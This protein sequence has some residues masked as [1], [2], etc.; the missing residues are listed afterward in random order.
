MKFAQALQVLEAGGYVFRRGWNGKQIVLFLIRGTDL[1][2]VL[3]YGYGEYVGEPTFES[4][5]AIRT[6]QNTIALGW[7]PTN[8]DMWADDWEVFYK[9]F[10]KGDIVCYTDPH[11]LR[12]KARITK[13][14]SQECVNLEH[15]ESDMRFEKIPSSVPLYRDGMRSF[16]FEHGDEY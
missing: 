14:W 5:I 7:K 15:T 8:A 13:V 1:Q 11:R 9:P 4:T 2:K 3:G 12:Y 16:Y 10:E 6:A